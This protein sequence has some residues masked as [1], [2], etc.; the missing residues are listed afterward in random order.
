MSET[1][2]LFK[3]LRKKHPGLTGVMNAQKVVRGIRTDIPCVTFTVKQKKRL[4]DL[5]K[6]SILPKKIN[7][8]VTD[9]IDGDVLAV[10]KLPLAPSKLVV[11]GI[12]GGWVPSG[13]RTA[14][15]RPAPGGVSVGHPLITAGTLGGW[16]YQG[17]NPVIL[18]NNHV[19]GAINQAEPGDPIYQPGV[20]D[21]GGP[22]DRIASFVEYI[23]II[24][25]GD[26]PNM[27]DA[28][29]AS[30]DNGG[31]VDTQVAD[32]TLEMKYHTAAQVAMPC[33]KSGRTTQ[34]TEGAV[35]A[36][37]WSGL[38]GYGDPGNALYENQ[39]WI[40]YYDFIHGG[41]SGSILLQKKEE[42]EPDTL[43]GLCFAGTMAGQAVACPIDG[44]L[45]YFD[46]NPSGASVL[47]GDVTCGLYPAVGAIV[48]AFRMPSGSLAGYAIT[49]DNGHYSIGG[50]GAMGQQLFIAAHH[51]IGTTL[52]QTRNK[53]WWT[54]L[55]LDDAVNLNLEE[56]TKDPNGQDVIFKLFFDEW[57]QVE[58]GLRDINEYKAVWW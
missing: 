58:L 39:I 56:Y 18:S 29:I 10:S 6:N 25:D 12:M 24:L 52:F 50:V 1:L 35:T 21:G 51:Y 13:S 17:S 19:I 22:A 55:S 37:D 53:A 33:T 8:K 44:I 46:I 2:E 45:D 57:L 11:P 14:K 43:I 16:L 9:V 28:A 4:Q 36:I 34:V 23:E 15:Y 26:T 48:F 32:L 5:T 54:M 41:D 27:Y 3:E 7:G 20:Y 38:V 42:G 30:A 40:D 31:D 49:D 47:S